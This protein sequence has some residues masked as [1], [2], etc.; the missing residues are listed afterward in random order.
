ML[1]TNQGVVTG[2]VGTRE[3]YGMKER[4]YIYIT[5]LAEI[6]YEYV[7]EIFLTDL[8]QGP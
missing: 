7:F 5:G 2:N 3:M 1:I 4:L 8:E 6:R